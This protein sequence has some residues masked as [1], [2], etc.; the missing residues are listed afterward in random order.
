[1]DSPNPAYN[2]FWMKLQEPNLAA[3]QALSFYVKGDRTQGY[4][5][6]VRLELKSAQ[7]EV[8]H[9]LLQ[10]ITDEWKQ[11]RIPLQAFGGLT[12]VSRTTEFV[13]VFDDVTSIKK[14]GTI[15]LDDIAF[16]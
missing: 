2:G 9:Y 11:V 5:P 4:T 3:S 8:G 13:V 14:V 6:Q 1:M 7:G 10:G 15:Y 16:Q 12:D